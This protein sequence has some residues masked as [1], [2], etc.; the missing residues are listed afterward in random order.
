M[1]T[2]QFHRDLSIL[3]L[4]KDKQNHT[5]LFISG[6]FSLDNL[7]DPIVVEEPVKEKNQDI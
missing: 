6:E 7:P 2:S 4:S 3:K 1:I 5:L